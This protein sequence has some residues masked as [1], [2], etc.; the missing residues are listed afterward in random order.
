MQLE[1]AIENNPKIEYIFV[2][3]SMHTD[4]VFLNLLVKD[5]ILSQIEYNMYSYISDF[6]KK[7]AFKLDALIF[8][9]VDLQT[10]MERIQIRNRKGES[11]ITLEYQNALYKEYENWIKN[12]PKIPIKRINTNKGFDSFEELKKFVQSI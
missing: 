12:N 1:E 8:L 6:M 5:K 7:K 3:R 2:E 4:I 11:N 9:D 10:A